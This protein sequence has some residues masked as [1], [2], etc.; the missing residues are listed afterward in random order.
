MAVTELRCNDRV[1]DTE[2]VETM[3]FPA[4]PNLWCM[5][6]VCLFCETDTDK[7]VFFYV[8]SV[9]LSGDWDDA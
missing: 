8:D 4:W 1:F 6:N 5:L 9:L 3:V 2:A 7:R